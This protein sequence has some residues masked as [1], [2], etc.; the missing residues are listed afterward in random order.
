LSSPSPARAHAR[1]HRREA[2]ARLQDLLSIPSVSAVADHRADVRRAAD[3]VAAQLRAAGLA[4]VRVDETPGHPVVYGAWVQDSTAPTALIYGHYDVQPP[5]PVEAWDSPPFEPT[6]RDGAI[7]ARGAS[8][9]KGQMLIHLEALRA[10]NETAGRPP[11]NVKLVLEGEEEIGSAHLDSW[12]EAHAADLAADVAV[13]SDTA[14]AGPGRP[15]IVYGLRGLVYYDLTVQGPARDLHSG[16]FGGAVLNPIHALSDIISGLHD[17]TGRVAIPGFYDRV[18]HLDDSEGANLARVPFDADAFRRATGPA[19]DWG[20]AGYSIGE[21]LGARPTLDVNGIWGG[22]TGKGAK[23]VIP[24]RAHAKVSMRLVPNQEP[25]EVATAFEARVRELCPE[26]ARV[27]TRNL[28]SAGAVLVDRDS[29]GVKAAMMAYSAV[30]GQEPVFALE[31]GSIPVVSSFAAILSLGTVL[32]GFGL[33]DDNLHAPNEHFT[34]DNFY[35]GIETAIAFY[36][37]LPSPRG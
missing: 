35:R 1:D 37:F 16:Q 17:S 32:M 15:S 3:W 10:F 8:D 2:L 24:A 19:G 30:F 7:F 26:G 27:E 9:D 14:M 25:A 13:V 11:V 20:E 18:R 31:G 4:E 36:E 34:L 23:T 21:R 12:L 5:D 29:P 28:S 6:L 33:P 22:W